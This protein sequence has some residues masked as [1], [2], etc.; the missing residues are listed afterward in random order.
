MPVGDDWT[1]AE[2]RLA[3]A[4][5]LWM[6]RQE[7]SRSPYVKAHEVRRLQESGLDRPKGSIEYKYQNISAV[8]QENGWPNI[9]GYIPA[10]NVQKGLRDEVLKQVSDDREL[11]DLV[12]SN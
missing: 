11:Q 4:S 3:V 9:D 6:L 7:L 8:L 12:M 5:Y 10:R 1:H 2:N